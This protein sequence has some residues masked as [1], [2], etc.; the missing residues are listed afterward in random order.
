MPADALKCKECSTDLPARGALRLRALLRPAR[1]RLRARRRRRADELQA[2]DPGGPAHALALRGLP[3]AGGRRRA[4]RCPT[5]WTPLVRPTGSPSASGSAR[6]GSRT[7]P[8]TRRTRSRTASSRSRSPARRSSAS[9]RSPAPRPATSPTRSRPTPPPPGCTSYV[10]IP[11]DLEEQ[12]ILATG[13]YGTQPRRGPRQLRRRQPPLHRAL[14]RA[15]LGVRERQH[16]PVLRRGLQD[17]RVRDRRAARLGAARPRRRA[18]RLGLAVHQ[19]RARLRGVASTPACSTA[20][21]PTMNGAQAAGLLAGRAGVRRRARRLPPGQAGHDRQ[22]AGDRQPGRRPVRARARAH[23]PAARSTRS[24]TTRSAPGI[25]LLAET[26]GIFTETAG[27]V[28]TA[29]LAKLAERGDIGPRRA[30]R[31][32]S[33]AR[34]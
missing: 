11:A 20:S 30:R 8:P 18:D 26:T 2:P 33:P 14:G 19:D 23:A 15:R 12:K 32:S 10:F 6:C 29:V 28:T 1:G 5:G 7:T 22:V 3:A 13:V 24:P 9:T 16:A 4:R 31:A 27:G 34:A 25:R 17:A 21:V